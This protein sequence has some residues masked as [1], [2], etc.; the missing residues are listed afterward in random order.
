MLIYNFFIVLIYIFQT[1]SYYTKSLTGSSYSEIYSK[2]LSDDESDTYQGKDY[3]NKSPYYIYS[4]LLKIIIKKNKFNGDKKLIYEYANGHP[5]SSYTYDTFFNRVLSFSDGLNTYE[6]TGIQVKK[7]NEEQN[8]GMFRLLGLYGSNSANWITA[9]ISCMLSG[10]T[11]VVMHSKFILNEIVDILNEVKLE[12]L[13]LD[14]DFVE[15]LLYLKSSLPHLKKL[16]ILDTFINPSICNRKG[17]KSKNGDE[18]QAVGNNGEKEE[19]EEH[20]GEAEEDDEDD[21]EDDEDG[22]D[23]EDDD[24]DEKGDNIKDDYLYKKQNEIPNENI[25]E[26]QGEGEDQRNVH[27]TVQPTPYGA[28][29]KQY[30]KKKKKKGLKMLKK[31]RNQI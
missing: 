13:C 18:G 14:L 20:K 1:A 19:K 26:E 2:S 7:Y 10:V 24:D 12:W 21:D 8:N 6:G 22:E 16:I 9:D 5:K 15:N 31:E 3:D 23:G 4:H 30:L 27:Q 11:T 28:N 17:G 29:T 25:V